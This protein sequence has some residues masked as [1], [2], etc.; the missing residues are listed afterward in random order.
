[1]SEPVN[2]LLPMLGLTMS[3]GAVSRWLRDEGDRV[4]KGDPLFEVETDKA[5]LDVEA[6][7][8]GVLLR[9][10]VFENQ[11]VPVGTVVA[12]I[13]EPG[14][15]IAA[16]PAA[17][18]PPAKKTVSPRARK[19]A[20][21]H[22]LDWQTLEGSGANGL[23]TEDDVK[24]SLASS[25]PAPEAPGML[26]AHRQVLADRLSRSVRE[27]PHIYLTLT[28]DMA[29]A[30]AFRAAH[31]E[32]SYND[33]FLKAAATCLAEFPVVNASLEDG[34]LTRHPAAHI[35][36]AVASGEDNLFVP[37][38]RDAGAKTLAQ[39]A[40]ARRA[41]GEKAKA[42]RLTSDEMSG[43]TFTISNLGMYGVE[44]FTAIINPPESAIL[45]L[46]A[47][48]D[49]V[50]AIDGVPAVRPVMSVTLAADHRVVDGALAARFLARF[51]A[52]MENPEA[53]P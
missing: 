40:E 19:L 14:S 22:G 26:S 23:I 27:R 50:R 11:T 1:M 13:G 53:L 37:V 8:D 46:G 31:P 28:V 43:G 10:L 45:A 32:V 20:G 51:K 17:P 21:E 5:V 15:V 35:G 24:R 49:E 44:Q 3:E 29:A 39:I 12:V 41:L 30:A 33:L 4:R 47:V 2:V 25:A 16:A 38:I 42:K 7:A 52:L 34:R 6:P 36:F 9:R 18:P 48:R